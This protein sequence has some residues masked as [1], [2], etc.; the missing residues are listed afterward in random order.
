MAVDAAPLPPACA[1]SK[2]KK[3]QQST[4][5]VRQ[6]APPDVLSL[7]QLLPSTRQLLSSPTVLKALGVRPEEI[8]ELAKRL[9]EEGPPRHGRGRGGEPASNN[10]NNNNSNSNSNKRRSKLEELREREIQLAKLDAA[11]A[12]E[13]QGLCRKREIDTMLGLGKKGPT[14]PMIYGEPRPNTPDPGGEIEE[15]RKKR[16]MEEV[17]SRLG[18]SDSTIGNF[19]VDNPINMGVATNN[20]AALRRAAIDALL[21]LIDSSDILPAGAKASTESDDEEALSRRIEFTKRRIGK[22]MDILDSGRMAQMDLILGLRSMTNT[23]D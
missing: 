5:A 23:W 11:R 19:T 21:G 8:P 10:N 6:L 12:A 17:D 15:Q 1:P 14:V 9:K 16:R 3:R 18:L 22:E 4:P 20:M 2:S 7:A 13:K